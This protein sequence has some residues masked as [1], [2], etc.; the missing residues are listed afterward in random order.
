MPVVV[1]CD[2]AG[3]Y[4][5]QS[6]AL[7]GS[8][9][10]E[11]INNGT[12]LPPQHLRIPPPYQILQRGELTFIT[13]QCAHPCSPEPELSLQEIRVLKYVVTGHSLQETAAMLYISVRTVRQH[14][15]NL[16]KKLNAKSRDHLMA[17]AG[18]MGLGKPSNFNE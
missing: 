2:E 16:K 12:W 15:E 5:I 9:L 7:A 17:L 11:A 18:S 3:S 6:T 13:N 1:I 10:T 14:L 4:V 8:E